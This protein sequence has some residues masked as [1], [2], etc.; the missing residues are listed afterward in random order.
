MAVNE[1]W[2]TEHH[3][4]EGK[5]YMCAIKDVYSSPIT[6]KYA[7]SSHVR[8]Y[9]PVLMTRFAASTRYSGV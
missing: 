6:H 7:K 8:R 1:L 5:L 4:D 2:I 3:T 9:R